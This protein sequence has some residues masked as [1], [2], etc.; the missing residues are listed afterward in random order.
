MLLKCETF[1]D[2]FEY[3]GISS[4]MSVSHQCF[5]SIIRLSYGLLRIHVVQKVGNVCSV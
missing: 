2:N 4:F 3:F 1:S 5:T